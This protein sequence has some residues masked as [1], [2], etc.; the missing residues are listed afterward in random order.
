MGDD[1]DKAGA[2]DAKAQA[3]A[4]TAQ[5]EATLKEGETAEWGGDLARQAREAAHR[6][7]IAEADKVASDARQD[8]MTSLIPDLSKVER[9]KLDVSGD[10]P[11]FGSA[12]AYRALQA[13]A[14]KV[15]LEVKR[16]FGG[17]KEV[18]L[19]IT[20]DEDLATSDSAFTEVET[21]LDQLINAADQLIDEQPNPQAWDGE[22]P[23]FAAVLLAPLAFGAALGAGPLAL[24]AALAQAVPSVLSLLSAHRSVSA[25]AVTLDDIAATS[26]VA[27][28]M[29][30]ENNNYHVVHDLFR[31]VPSG[32]IRQK[33]NQLRTCR[34]QLIARK[35]ELAHEK[36]TGETELSQLRERIKTLQVKAPVPR[37]ELAQTRKELEAAQGANS[38]QVLRLGLI[39]SLLS[40][41][42]SFSAALIAVP[43]GGKRSLL[44]SAALREQLHGTVADE[45]PEPPG[46]DYVM[47]VK[48]ASGSSQQVVDDRPLLFDDKFATVTSMSL[49]YMLIRTTNSRVV[50]GGTVST[51]AEIH[52]SIDDQFTIRVIE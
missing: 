24:G 19:L 1:N 14:A 38:Q 6:K 37:T 31:L 51:T 11:L 32:R 10:Q 48:G 20:S 35:L 3:E 43:Q 9:G 39:D 26:A 40:V 46:F 15:A 13:A 16:R 29:L 42:D 22:P 36:V 21:G 50:A 33:A 34:Q 12:L 25:S 8:Q 17:A 5:A 4:R 27:G 49:T 7:T 45:E 28:A 47:L 44:A 23:L 2:A 30:E 18:S 41:I 52:G